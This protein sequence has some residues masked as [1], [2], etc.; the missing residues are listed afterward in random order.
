MHFIAFF[1]IWFFISILILGAGNYGSRQNSY[2]QNALIFIL[3]LPFAL[4]IVVL[5]G[6]AWV[7]SKIW[8]A[9]E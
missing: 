8:K 3:G 7:G 5:S 1:C 4:V 2:K 9:L 6:L